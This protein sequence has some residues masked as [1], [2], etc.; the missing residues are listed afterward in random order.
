MPSCSAAIDLRP[1]RR[2]D[3]RRVAEIRRDVRE[4]RPADPSKVTQAEVLWY[5][6]HAIFLVSEDEHAIQGFVCANPQ[7]GFVWALFVDDRAQGRGHGTLLL[8]AALGRLRALGHRQVH[9][10][11]G[12]DTRAHGFYLRHGFVDMGAAFGGERVLVAHLDEL[13]SP[14][15]EGSR[16]ST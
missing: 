5:L 7:T 12:A 3:F 11:T 13:A 10:T 9:L 1:A 15:L 4:N 8:D 14:E 16:P 2:D 6:D